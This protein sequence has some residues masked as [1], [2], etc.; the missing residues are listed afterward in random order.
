MGYGVGLDPTSGEYVVFRNGQRIR[1]FSSIPAALTWIDN[2]KVGDGAIYL[3]I[4][5][6]IGEHWKCGTRACQCSCHKPT[7]HEVSHA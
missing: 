6:D 3:S 7:D 4:V 2:D 5:C 1:A